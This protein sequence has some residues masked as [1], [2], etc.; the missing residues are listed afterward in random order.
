MAATTPPATSA[1]DDL[2]H[3]DHCR[4]VFERTDER[5]RDAFEGIVEDAEISKQANRRYRYVVFE[6]ER[7][8]YRVMFAGGV[9]RLSNGRWNCIGFGADVS[10]EV[11]HAG[12]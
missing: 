12:D 7:A 9:H 2:A 1:I 6:T 5:A 11:G 8:A 10:Q 4:V 3:G